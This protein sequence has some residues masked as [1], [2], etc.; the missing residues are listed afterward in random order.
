MTPINPN[1]AIPKTLKDKHPHPESPWLVSV[2]LFSRIS[3]Q[4]WEAPENVID[5]G[6]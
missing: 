4:S 3:N 2:P 6:F 5:Q 1:T